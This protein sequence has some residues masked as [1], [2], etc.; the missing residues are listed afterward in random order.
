MLQKLPLLPQRGLSNFCTRLKG[1][2]PRRK[3][4]VHIL[5]M[6]HVPGLNNPYQRQNVGPETSPT[7]CTWVQQTISRRNKL[8]QRPPLRHVHGLNS[9]Y[10]W[11][12]KLVQRL[13]LRQYMALAYIR[14]EKSWS[15]EFPYGMIMDWTAHIRDQ[16]FGPK[17]FSTVCTWPK[18]PIFATKIVWQKTSRVSTVASY[19]KHAS[20][21]GYTNELPTTVK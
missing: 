2:Y 6:R 5:P 18:Q 20:R 4:L 7:A 19:R 12:K 1:L 15:W 3:T 11:R 17:A 8:V 9:L 16:N 14:D 13:A 21:T 10:P